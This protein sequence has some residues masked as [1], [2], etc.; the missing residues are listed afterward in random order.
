MYVTHETIKWDSPLSL[1]YVDKLDI[2]D[3]TCLTEQNSADKN[4]AKFTLVLPKEEVQLQVSE[5]TKLV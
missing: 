5:E 3:L 4:C 2:I 1:Q